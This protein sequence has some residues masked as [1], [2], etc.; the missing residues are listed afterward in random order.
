[1]NYQPSRP[2]YMNMWHSGCH[3]G[4]FMSGLLSVGRIIRNRR[5]TAFLLAAMALILFPA[6]LASASDKPGKKD[7]PAKPIKINADSLTI[8]GNGNWAEFT[9]NVKVVQGKTTIAAQRLRIYYKGKGKPDQPTKNKEE[10]ELEKIEAYGNVRIVMDNRVAVTPKAVYS[11]ADQTLTLEGDGSRL[12]SGKDRVSGKK[13]VFFRQQGRI[14]VTGSP[15]KQVQAI[16][17]S[18]K[19]TLD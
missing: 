5:F 4:F 11:T 16:I 13:I 19:E 17:F 18:D 10:A 2:D 14:K 1:M 15:G 6:S 3:T 12:Q 7:T 9:G 8:N